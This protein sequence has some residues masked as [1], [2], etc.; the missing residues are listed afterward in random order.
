MNKPMVSIII[1]NWNGREDLLR[2]IVSLGEVDYSNK[3]IIVVDNG[4]VDRSVELLNR[5]FP[6]VRFIALGKNVGHSK[7]LNIGTIAAQG[8]FILHLDNDIRANDT[9]FLSKL[10][11]LMLSDEKIGAC[12]PMVLNMDTNVIQIMGEYVDMSRGTM[13]PAKGLNEVDCGQYAEPFEVD[14]V[15]GCAILFRRSV[16]DKVGLYIARYVV[17]FDETD[18]CLRIKKAGYRILTDPRAKIMHKIGGSGLNP[19]DFAVYQSIKNRLFFMRRHASLL[20]WIAFLPRFIISPQPWF[21]RSFVLRQPLRIARLTAKALFWNLKDIAF[22]GW[23]GMETK[24]LTEER[25]L[26]HV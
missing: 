15:R 5:D 24:N 22:A 25:N 11:D 3:E 23:K 7:G 10:V 1:V 26:L 2:C 21:S 19:G 17:Y 12:G 20:N 13:R 16:L 8:E 14:Y 18:L 9:T 4:S 6:A